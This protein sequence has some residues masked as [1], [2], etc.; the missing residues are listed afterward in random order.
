MEGRGV[1]GIGGLVGEAY[2][3]RAWPCYHLSNHDLVR[4]YT[5]SGKGGDTE[6]R[7]KV[8]AAMLLTLR[9][10]PILYY[11]EEIGM[12]ASKI[13]RRKILDSIGRKF[14]PLD[15]GRDK[16]RTP[17]QRSD[18]KNAGFSSADPF[19]PVDPSYREKNVQRRERDPASL[20]NWYRSLIRLR[21]ESP[22]L[23]AGDYRSLDGAPPGVF[24]YTREAEGEKI[25][26]LLNFPSGRVDVSGVSG[27]PEGSLQVILS[28]H[29]REREKVAVSA[30]ALAPDEALLLVAPLR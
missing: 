5:R 25:A 27:E 18:G 4:H 26:V 6:A 20:L 10:T 28:T 19:L 15:V 2:S 8:A 1:P 17:M 13:P 14:W 11:G 23:Q 22:A 9:G 30:L 3:R 7:A 16:S 24:A 29:R 12:P 21:K